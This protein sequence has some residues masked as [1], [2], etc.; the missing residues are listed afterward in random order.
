MNLRTRGGGQTEDEDD[1]GRQEGFRVNIVIPALG[2]GRRSS[3]SSPLLPAKHTNTPI[4]HFPGAAPIAP[5][6]TK[7]HCELRQRRHDTF[8]RR[9]RR[10]LSVEAMSLSDTRLKLPIS[11][12]IH[13]GRTREML[14]RLI[15]SSVR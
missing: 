15:E 2:L 14:Y 6:R 11:I 5:P 10:F 4:S 3:M 9:S 13:I 1:L 8:A 7:Q 12:S